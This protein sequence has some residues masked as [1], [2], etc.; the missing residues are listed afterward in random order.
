MRDASPFDH[1]AFAP[2]RSLLDGERM[3]DL[4]Q[5]N[6]MACARGLALDNGIPLAFVAATPASALAYEQAIATQ[7]RIGIRPG[8]WHDAFNA[9]V[10]L[11]LPRTKCAL[12]ALHAKAAVAPGRHARTRQR[13]AATLVDES[14]LILACAD[15]ALVGLLRQRAWQQLFVTARARVDAAFVPLVVGH[16]MLDKLRRPWRGITAHVLIIPAAMNG[17][18]DSAAVATLDAAAAAQ[19][20]AESFLPAVLL[21]LPVAA[22]AGWDGEALGPRLY[23][24]VSIFRPSMLV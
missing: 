11:T 6:A 7:G 8:S 5:L 15:A 24:D 21:P 19:I 17:P 4:L 16:G 18:A 14:G 22:L 10:W 20:R 13:D 23:D 9:L 2:F 12:N 1:P 3:P